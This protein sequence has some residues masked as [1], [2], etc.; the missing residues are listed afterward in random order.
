[1]LWAI[2]HIAIVNILSPGTHIGLVQ[3]LYYEPLTAN[4]SVGY[5]CD[6]GGGHGACDGSQQVLI[7][8]MGIG[9]YGKGSLNNS[10]AEP[11][12][13]ECDSENFS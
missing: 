9:A 13:S 6:E 10:G 7:G 4:F 3:L 2:G 11:L 8:V 1:M 12:S 5:F